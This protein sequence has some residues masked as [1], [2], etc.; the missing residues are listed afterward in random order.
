M[1]DQLQEKDADVF[2]SPEAM[3]PTPAEP[4][5]RGAMAT[6]LERIHRGGHL[7]ASL[8]NLQL[9]CLTRHLRMSWLRQAVLPSLAPAQAN[10]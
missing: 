3:P 8:L 7:L 2:L 9:P 5:G 1:V 4:L 10:P 6:A